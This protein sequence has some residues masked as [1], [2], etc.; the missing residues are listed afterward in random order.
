MSSRSLRKKSGVISSI[1][2]CSLLIVV[3]IL[4]VIYKQ[5]IID[6]VIVWQYHPTVE[7]ITLV[8]RAGMN[9][10]GKFYYMAS[11]PT[12]YSPESASS[13]NT[14]CNRVESTTAILG[15]YT[16]SRLY[17]YDVSDPKLDGISEVTA[18]HET[19]HAIYDRMSE[20]DKLEV[21]KLLQAEYAKLATNKDFA[22]LMAFYARAE[23]GQR[24]NELHSIIGTEVPNI[25]LKLEAYY[26]KYFSDRQKVVDLNAK[27]SGVFKGLKARADQLNGQLTALK[28][29]ITTRSAQYN[30]D[31][32]TLN[33]NISAFNVRA[34]GGDFS[35]QSQFNSERDALTTRAADLDATRQS[36]NDDITNYEAM[37]N[38]YNSIASESTKLYNTINSDLVPAP[39]V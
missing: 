12:L 6:Q 21:N 1:A 15:C 23:P 31:A 24:L 2:V 27:Y 3:S 25:S 19:L 29:R 20:S 26:D 11:Q 4:F 16:G 37:V 14:E 35:S 9:A 28:T 8:D 34:G 17:I 36:I 5:R 18:A 39:S 33:S 13:F 22:E 10:N 7:A 38:E 32:Q 30:I